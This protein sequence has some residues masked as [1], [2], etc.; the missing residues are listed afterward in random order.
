MKI[1]VLSDIHANW[2][3]LEAILAKE[4]YNALIFLG[5]VVDFGPN[6]RKCVRFLM[7]SSRNRFWGVRGDHDHALAYGINCG[8]SLNLR[9]LSMK[10]REWGEGLVASDEVGF[11]RRL[12]FEN[13]AT[14]DGL[15]FHFMH[16]SKRDRLFRSITTDIGELEIENEFGETDTDFIL[17]G[18][19]HKPFI[20]HLGRV[21]V[22]N[23]GSVGQPR[24][25]NP[26]AS[27]AVIEDGK[28]MIKRVRY[29]IEKTVRDLEKSSLPKDVIRELVSILVIG[30]L[31][32]D[33]IYYC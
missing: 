33:E 24:D 25:F 10:T 14:L 29:D 9:E 5:D 13:H 20:I 15:K 30:G 3:A 2:Y 22:L 23:P 19:S 8:S 11:L 7:D 4:S 1:L 21:T 18:H 6:P 26:R 17:I 12:P 28:A 31:V 27:Y 16:G 32:K